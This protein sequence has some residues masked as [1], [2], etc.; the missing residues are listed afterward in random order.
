MNDAKGR[1][2]PGLSGFDF[3]LAILTLSRKIGKDMDPLILISIP[4]S[5]VLLA[6]ILMSGFAYNQSLLFRSKRL[7]AETHRLF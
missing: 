6:M 4:L 7:V 2:S 1:D 3:V 5:F